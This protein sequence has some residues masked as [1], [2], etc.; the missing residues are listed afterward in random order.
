MT[1]KANTGNPGFAIKL[2]RKSLPGVKLAKLRQLFLK[3]ANK[4]LED[5]GL[6]RLWKLR[7]KSSFL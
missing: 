1:S 7:K 3:K 4:I 5:S 2:G 6:L